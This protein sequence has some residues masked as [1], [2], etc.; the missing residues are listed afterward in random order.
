M[1]KVYS[2]GGKV[3]YD[4]QK[5]LVDTEEEVSKVPLCTMGSTIYVIRTGDTWMMDSEGNWY[6]MTGTKGSIPCDCVSELTIWGDLK[7]N[8][9]SV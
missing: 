5:W 4:I 7:E 9:V 3:D 1:I 8:K 6:E 2:N